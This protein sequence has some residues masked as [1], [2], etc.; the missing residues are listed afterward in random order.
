M[1]VNNPHNPIGVVH[2]RERW[3]RS[4]PMLPQDRARDRAL[5]RG[6]GACD[7]RRSGAYFDDGDRGH[8]RAHGEGRFRPAR[9]FADRL[10]G[11]LRLLAG[12]ILE[13]LARTHQFITFTTPPNPSAVAYGL[14]KDDEYFHSMRARLPTHPGPLQRGPG[15]R[16]ASSASCRARR[17]Y[18]VAIDIAAMGHSD[19]A[20]FCRWLVE[21]HGVA[22]IPISA[23][24]ETRAIRTAVRFCFA[25]SNATLKHR[26]RAFE[27]GGGDGGGAITAFIA[28]LIALAANALEPAASPF[29]P[30]PATAPK[31]VRLC[32]APCYRRLQRQDA[33]RFR[34]GERLRGR[35]R[36]LW[37][38][39]TRPG[40]DEGGALPT[41][42]FCRGR[43]SPAQLRPANT[44]NRQSSGS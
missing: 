24:Y 15:W 30:P 22:A 38:T 32:C 39:D 43:P 14:M 40:D 42:S 10:E 35:L 9:C 2:R 4:S 5:R 31:I 8:A 16:N 17:T 7:V 27:P 44:Q 1:L 37:R 28:A 13:T 36:R 11:R 3:R 25:K 12:G 19:D 34:A 33:R 26:A 41:S 20:A 18:F 21:T 23:F 29:A 6:P